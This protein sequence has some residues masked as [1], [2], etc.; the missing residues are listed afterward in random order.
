MAALEAFCKR[1]M[2]KELALFGSALRNDFG[3]ESDIDLLVTFTPEAHPSLFDLAGMESEFESLLGRKVD[4]VS[5][6]GIERSKNWIR[7]EEILSA[8]RTVYAA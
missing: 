8:A 2:V 7:R 1:W 4:L 6:R 3:A 5:R